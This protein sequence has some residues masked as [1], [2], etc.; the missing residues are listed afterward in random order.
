MSDSR[1]TIRNYRASD[2]DGFVQLRTEAARLT[3]DEGCLSLQV[4][5]ENLG[6]PNY[7]PE[8]DLFLAEISGVIVG[9]LDVVPEVK[10]GR[11][12]LNCFIHPQHRRK[13]LA[14]KLLAHAVRRAKAL[15]AQV[16]HVNIHQGN[17]VAQRVLSGLGFR[18][19]RRAHELELDLTDIPLLEAA[20]SFPIR[21]LEIGEEA[22]LTDIQNRSFTGSWGYH[23]NTKEQIK[24]ETSMSNCEREGILLACEGDSPVGYCWTR[25]E[26]VEGPTAD[27][28]KGRI[29]M[30]GVD[31]DYRGTGIGKGLLLAGLSY[32]KGQGLRVAQLTVDSENEVADALYRSVGF[33]ICD[34]S[35]WYE[36]V[37]D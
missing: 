35:L 5:R 12:V 10:I 34:S 11:V 37:L 21:H 24:Y 23:P 18:L 28:S 36:K 4:I 2:F 3:A 6:R 14:T 22:K 7:L 33:K 1:Y 15:G 27:E 8:Q 9:Y 30:I 13:G 32:L 16:A 20:A 17:T 31:P 29:F 25:I 26:G 19:I